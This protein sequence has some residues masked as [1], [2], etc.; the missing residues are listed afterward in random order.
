MDK[1]GM[2]WETDSGPVG[3]TKNSIEWIM[4]N[5]KTSQY[6]KDRCYIYNKLLLDGLTTTMFT[7]VKTLIGMVTD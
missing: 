5:V 7:E 4:D 2:Q 3:I 6:T 1:I